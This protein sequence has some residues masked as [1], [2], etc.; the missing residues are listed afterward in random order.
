MFL[1]MCVNEK[2]IV[3]KVTFECSKKTFKV[4]KIF[5]TRKLRTS[6]NL[7]ITATCV[8]GTVFDHSLPVFSF[9]SSVHRV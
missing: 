2:E 9:S 8:P 6:S 3:T 7:C 5:E 4:G 1:V